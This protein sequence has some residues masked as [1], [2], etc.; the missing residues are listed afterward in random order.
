MAFTC[1]L[2][3]SQFPHELHLDAAFLF[4]KQTKSNNAKR[5]ESGSGFM[6][7]LRFGPGPVHARM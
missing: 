4:I 7:L 2:K 3:K 1:H 5:Q 6:A